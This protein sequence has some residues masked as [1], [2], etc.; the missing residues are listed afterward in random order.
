MTEK[1]SRQFIA[2]VQQICKK[3]DVKYS[4]QLALITEMTNAHRIL[5]E[6]PKRKRLHERFTSKWED[7]ANK[8]FMDSSFSTWTLVAGCFKQS[9]KIS[10]LLWDS[11][12]GVSYSDILSSCPQHLIHTSVNKQHFSSRTDFFYKP[13]NAYVA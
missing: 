3:G 11:A 12:H 13:A 8:S 1:I 5:V 10:S 7:K 6:E 2:N 4:G 9:K